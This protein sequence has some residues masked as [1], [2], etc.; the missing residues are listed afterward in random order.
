M[1]RE[2]GMLRSFG[3]TTLIL[4]TFPFGSISA[5]KKASPVD[6]T[7]TDL[8]GKRVHLRDYRGKIVVLN[9]WA[10]WCVPCQEEMPMLVEAEK[11]WSPKGV[12][13]L[14]ASLDEKATR[15]NVPEFIRK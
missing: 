9:F 6:L 13:F 14:G 8:D 11:A 12:I 10:T 5:P 1:Q 4:V 7:L 2:A 15:K 3:L